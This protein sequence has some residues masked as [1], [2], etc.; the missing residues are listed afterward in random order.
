[1][2]FETTGNDLWMHPVGTTSASMFLGTNSSERSPGF[3]PD[4]QYV[5][6][7]SDKTGRH[8]VYVRA[9]PSGEPELKIS[10]E[11][12][13][14]PRWRS[15]GEIF[16]L[17][18]DGTMMSSRAVGKAIPSAPPQ[19]LFATGLVLAQNQRHPYDV[20]R[21]GQQFLMPVS[22]EIPGSWPLTVWTNWTAKLPR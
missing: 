9:F 5:V 14:H 6:Y 10:R 19:Q 3:S 12:G 18:L 17:S 15:D 4:G 21:D 16:F 20:A 11:G 8:E 13:W 2:L 22:S 1:M 7:S